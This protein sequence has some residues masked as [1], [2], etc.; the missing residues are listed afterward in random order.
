MS[1]TEMGK[2]MGTN[3]SSILSLADNRQISV[4]V[5]EYASLAG[6]VMQAMDSLA[7]ELEHKYRRISKITEVIIK[8]LLKNIEL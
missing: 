6:K 4:Q 1:H 2:I 3:E 7:K 5:E 8:Y